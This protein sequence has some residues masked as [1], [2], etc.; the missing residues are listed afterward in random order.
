MKVIKPFQ[1]GFMSRTFSKDKRF[2]VSVA[3]MSYF[4]FHNSS[5]LG[6][7]QDMWLTINEALGSETIFDACM[8]KVQGEI[9][10]LGNCYAPEQKPAKQLYVDLDVGNLLKRVVVTGDRHWKRG[11][12]SEGFLG[13]VIDNDWDIS[14]AEPFSEMKMDWINAFGGENYPNNPLGKGYIKSKDEIFEGSPLPNIEASHHIVISPTDKIQPG[15]YGPIDP[16]WPVRHKK[17]GKKYDKNWEKNHYPEPSVDFDDTFYNAAPFDQQLDEK[18]WDGDEKIVITNMH[19]TEQ[20]LVTTIPQVRPRCFILQR[21]KDTERWNE[22]L[23]SPETIWLFPNIKKGILISRG[24]YEVDTFYGV[25]IATMLLA[26]EL[27]NG[28]TRNKED[29]R[30]SVRRREDK[31]EESAEWVVRQ[32]DL[33]PPEGIPEEEEL[34]A[35]E[36]EI[37]REEKYAPIIERTTKEINEELEKTKEFALSLGLK[38]EEVMPKLKAPKLSYPKVPQLK[39][40][41]DLP[42]LLDWVKQEEASAA[43]ALTAAQSQDSVFLSE[44]KDE[45][46]KKIQAKVKEACKKC[47]LDYD[48]ALA[49]SKSNPASNDSPF[50]QFQD[51]LEKTKAEAA[52]KNVKT[53]EIDAALSKLKI[54]EKQFEDANKQIDL[55]GLMRAGAH[56]NEKPPE[57][58]EIK[59]QELRQWVQKEY[60]AGNTFQD[61][62]LQGADLSNMDLNEADFKGANLDSVNFSNCNLENSNLSEAILVRTNFESANV[63][64]ATFEKSNLGYATFLKTKLDESNFSKAVI[65]Q[66]NFSFASLVGANMQFDDCTKS[67]FFRANLNNT[68]FNEMDITETSLKEAVLQNSNFEKSTFM[69]CNLE[70]AD[71]SNSKLIE[72]CFIEVN[73]QECKFNDSDMLNANAHQDSNFSKAS[74]VNANCDSVNF[75]NTNISDATFEFSNLKDADFN[76]STLVNTIFN[77]CTA[78]EAAFTDADSRFASFSEANLMNASFQGALL[79][80]ANFSNAHLF[81][82]DFTFA[83]YQNADFFGAIKTRSSLKEDK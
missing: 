62:E 19:K 81:G 60:E 48:D 69:S 55:K 36:D 37:D 77:Q 18:Y 63:K 17:M 68:N 70:K 35:D 24:T 58:P 66:T 56:C 29:Y 20:K 79:M 30:E 16:S 57:L 28:E 21:E 3:V 5:A 14:A 76:E 49:K 7:E 41:S 23:L 65:E 74:F 67:S 6:T 32:D 52:Q 26:W 31:E 15:G 59:K 54:A 10:M 51:V 47:G 33:S 50:K 80:N 43:K 53:P 73:A 71:F 38:P 82:A 42:A 46:E 25:D 72:T 9:I 12:L 64:K 11:I 4:P 75:A 44:T 61:V 45:A 40:M 8:P 22:I 2:Y 1:L 13:R 34:L 83:Q 78:N 39:K 27:K